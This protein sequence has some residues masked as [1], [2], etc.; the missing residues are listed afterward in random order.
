MIEYLEQLCSLLSLFSVQVREEKLVVSEGGDNAYL[1]VSSPL[2]PRLSCANAAV[3]T[4]RVSTIF[5]QKRRDVRC[6]D[7]RIIPQALIG[8]TGGDATS[9]FCGVE[10]TDSNW[11]NGT[12]LAVS[13]V[14]DGL[15]D[16]MQKR[17]LRV[18]AQMTINA[19]V[20]QQSIAI[21]DVEV[22]NQL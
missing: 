3:C 10:L 7:D 13:A 20:Q 14:I 2:P 9:A 15:K 16:R 21:K 17:K 8:W 5:L 19:A 18:S 12:R 1:T 4:W 11:M 22:C 6:A